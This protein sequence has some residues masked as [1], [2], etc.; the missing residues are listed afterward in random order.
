MIYTK[1]WA[2][3]EYADDLQTRNCLSL[4]IR[5][6]LLRYISYTIKRETVRKQH[7]HLEDQDKQDFYS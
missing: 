7:E 1:G 5:R 2:I 3:N 6:Y 4:Q